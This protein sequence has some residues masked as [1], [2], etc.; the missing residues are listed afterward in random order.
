[1]AKTR[2][3]GEVSSAKGILR[4]ID[5]AELGRVDDPRHQPW[6]VHPLKALLCL[7]VTA[8]ATGARS[9]REVEYRSEQLHPKTR[10]Q[11]GLE[12]MN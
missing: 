2:V 11:F 8:L 12:E 1:M 5:D 4:R 10:R 6:V 3:R 9:T 7:A